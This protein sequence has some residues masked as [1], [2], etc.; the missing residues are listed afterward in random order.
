MRLFNTYGPGEYFSEY[1]SAICKFIY[2]AMFKQPLTIYLDHR[3]TS[4]YVSDTCRT[5]ANISQ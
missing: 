3:R 4:T 1:R 5:L 2:K